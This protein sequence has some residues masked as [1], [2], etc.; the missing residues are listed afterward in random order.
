MAINYSIMTTQQLTAEAAPIVGQLKGS[1]NA[2][3][4]YLHATLEHAVKHSDGNVVANLY[5]LLKADDINTG[6]LKAVRHATLDCTGF[7]VN[8]TKDKTNGIRVSCKRDQ[9]VWA[10]TKGD[11]SDANLT[12][13]IGVELDGAGISTFV[14][15]PKVKKA[16]TSSNDDDG[17]GN[18][19]VKNAYEAA[20]GGIAAIMTEINTIAPND[21]EILADLQVLLAME[22]KL[23]AKLVKLK[24]RLSGSLLATG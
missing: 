1:K 19:E 15:R 16:T 7:V 23:K 8:C 24:Q 6:H 9:E 20:V 2:L 10:R 3:G 17:S 22:S 14:N 5:R 13:L 21:A 4:R 12:R 11:V 18:G